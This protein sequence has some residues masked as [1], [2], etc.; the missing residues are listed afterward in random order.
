M[1][2]TKEYSTLY[3]H[4]EIHNMLKNGDISIGEIVKLFLSPEAQ[5]DKEAVVGFFARFCAYNEMDDLSDQERLAAFA[6]FNHRLFS[7]LYGGF[8][9]E[10]VEDS[11]FENSKKAGIDSALEGISL[12]E[13]IGECSGILVF[14]NGVM[15]YVIMQDGSFFSYSSVARKE[16]HFSYHF[17][18]FDV[19]E[20]SQYDEDYLS[21]L[22]KALNVLLLKK[23]GL[24]ET[25]MVAKGVKRNFGNEVIVN[26]MPF[27]VHRLDSSWFKT[28]I[29][30]EGFM[31]RGFWRRQRCG[32]GGK[33][34]RLTYIGP[35]MKHGYHR[36]APALKA[37][38]AA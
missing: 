12:Y 29:R 36:V 37:R 28:I 6:S 32:K 14:P 23:F 25:M 11:F 33:E 5:I 30:D 16:S 19:R 17:G 35:F 26:K 8:K 7:R 10:V 31:V 1:R 3:A 9:A 22:C 4:H 13:T 21:H 2:I 24:V 27:P 15:Q 18:L 38:V 34:R 20:C